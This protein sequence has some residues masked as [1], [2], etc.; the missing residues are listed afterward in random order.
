MMD[1][2]KAPWMLTRELCTKAQERTDAHF[3]VQPEKRPLAD[4]LR[5]GIINLDKTRGPSSHEITAWLKRL[6]DLTH[7]GHGGTLVSS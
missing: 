7:A 1:R 2:L 3:G 4:Y 5:L 6:L